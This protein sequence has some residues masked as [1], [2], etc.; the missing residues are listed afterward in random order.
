MADVW[1]VVKTGNGRRRACRLVPSLSD[2][3]E[4]ESTP[5]PT[6]Q[7]S[8]LSVFAH[9]LKKGTCLLANFSMT[10]SQQATFGFSFEDRRGNPAPTPAGIQTPT[11]LTDSPA[12]LALAPSADGTSCVVSALGPLGDGTVSVALVDANGDPLASGQIDVTIVG[13]APTTVVI[14]AGTPTE[15]P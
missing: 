4:Q 1:I 2:V 9:V 8:L 6:P 10:D 14:T 5:A 3:R 7:H 13:G 12:L 11:W 15:Q